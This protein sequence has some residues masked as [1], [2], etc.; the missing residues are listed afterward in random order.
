M[1]EAPT[2]TPG[3]LRRLGS[4]LKSAFGFSGHPGPLVPGYGATRVND[5]WISCAWPMNYGQVGYD[6]TIAGYDDVVYACIQLYARTI[7]QL[8]GYHKRTG[9]DGGDVII[10]NDA[11]ARVLK[12]PNPYQ[13]KSDFLYNLVWGHLETGNS[14]AIGTRN[15][16]FEVTRLDLVNPW[17]TRPIVNRETG[18]VFYSIGTNELVDPL[19]DPGLGVS[20]WILPSEDVIHVRSHCPWHPL[21][22]ESPLIA[23]GAAV[24]IHAGSQANFAAF[25]ANQG[26]PSGVIYT[27]MKMTKA[28][29][30]ELRNAWNEATKGNRAGG[31]PILTSGLKWQQVTVNAQD[32]E[33]SDQM[34][35]AV[36]A[37]SR[38]FGVP[39]A[40]INDMSGATQTNVEQLMAMWLR[41]GLGYEVDVIEEQFDRLFE[42]QLSKDFT[43]FDV[44]AL[45]R[46]DWKT[47]I[48]ALASGVQGAI[49][50]PNEA[51]AKEGLK[52]VPNGDQPRVQQ[53]LV[54]LDWEP[55]E[56]NEP[57]AAAAAEDNAGEGAG[58][59]KVTAA[60]TAR[61]VTAAIPPRAKSCLPNS[62]F[63]ERSSGLARRPAP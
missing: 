23:A 25:Q 45:L 55:P 56:P 7:A 17:S 43:E 24:A 27:D 34:K 47:R 16:R 13:T 8:P 15:N 41:Q 62:C 48:E 9:A 40:L 19:L 39:L 12:A 32:A 37:I 63:R 28:Q 51:R 38:I 3:P 44:E 14:Y 33:T 35:Q 22:G 50:A 21:I 58:D 29:I 61:P 46:P 59:G 57:A 1:V 4:A 54:T 53:Q 60:A 26:R 42:I 11:L 10:D 5:G 36:A 2:K 49:Y 6:P 31:T 18:D 20:R 30:D 52:A